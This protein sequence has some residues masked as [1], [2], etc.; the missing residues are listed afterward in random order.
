MIQVEIGFQVLEADWSRDESA[1]ALVRRQVFIEEQAVPEAMEWE[2]QDPACDWFVAKDGGGA[3]VGIARL[4][5]DARIGRMAVLPGWRRRGVGT[6]LLQAALAKARQKG[7]PQVSLHAQV[8]ALLFY[9]RFGFQA[10]GPEFE[11]AGIPHREMSLVL[12]E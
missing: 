4:T 2:T 1:I 7:L 9:G 12:T 11:E 5:P 8:H 3:I 10:R 6:A